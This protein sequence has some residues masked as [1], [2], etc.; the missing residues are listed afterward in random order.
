MDAHNLRLG[1]YRVAYEDRCRELPVLAQEDG[2]RAGHVH[3]DQSVE[4]PG[5]QAALYDQALE[6]RLGC[7]RFIEVQRIM[8]SGQFGEGLNMIRG[9]RDAARGLL[10]DLQCHHG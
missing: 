7:K 8:V 9:Q 4:Q 6:L 1:A 10:S 3:G 5:R 2:P